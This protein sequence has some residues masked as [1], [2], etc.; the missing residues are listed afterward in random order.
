MAGESGIQPGTGS[1]GLPATH[2]PSVM[3]VG[4]QR[5]RIGYSAAFPEPASQVVTTPE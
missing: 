2:S 1:N 4:Y 5:S 3:S